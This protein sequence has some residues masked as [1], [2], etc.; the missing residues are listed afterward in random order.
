M[1]KTKAQNISDVL[2]DV[3]RAALLHFRKQHKMSAA[4]LA[5]LAGIARPYLTQFETGARRSIS[6][7]AWVRLSKQLAKIEPVENRSKTLSEELDVYTKRHA[8]LI[9]NDPLT[10]NDVSDILSIAQRLSYAL[11]IAESK[12]IFFEK[13]LAER[14]TEKL[15]EQ[16]IKRR[17]NLQS[18]VE[19]HL[20][21]IADAEIAEKDKALALTKQAHA[22]EMRKHGFKDGEV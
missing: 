19:P 4:K 12:A 11:A 6:A 9:P 21:K 14:P 16:E 3:R 15:L 1:D 8:G 18:L 13:A 22:E 10:L 5:K 2:W 7:K 20:T 17:E